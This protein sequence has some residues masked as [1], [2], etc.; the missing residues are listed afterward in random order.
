MGA[1]EASAKAAFQRVEGVQGF[2]FL[3]HDQLSSK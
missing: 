2:E 1:H 3:Q